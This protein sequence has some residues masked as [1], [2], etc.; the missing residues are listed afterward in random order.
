MF[1]KIQLQFAK[2]NAEQEKLLFSI[3]VVLHKVCDS[4]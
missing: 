4:Y 2:K 1:C 3:L